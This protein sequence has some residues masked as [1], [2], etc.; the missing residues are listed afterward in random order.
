MRVLQCTPKFSFAGLQLA[1]AYAAKRLSSD[2][3]TQNPK[4]KPR[5]EASGSWACKG[6]TSERARSEGQ[7]VWVHLFSHAG[8]LQG[9][10]VKGR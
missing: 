5:Q 9:L 4:K 8:F 7:V 2:D 1:R 6:L 3:A 10:Y